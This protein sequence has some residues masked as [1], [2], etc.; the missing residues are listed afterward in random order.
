MASFSQDK[1]PAAVTIA[2][3][4]TDVFE[5]YCAGDWQVI[6]FDLTNAGSTA[7]D[8]IDIMAKDHKDGSFYILSATV[9]AYTT[10]DPETLAGGGVSR[11]TIACGDLYAVKLRA[12]VAAGSTTAT[13]TTLLTKFGLAGAKESGGNL[14]TIAALLT[15]IDIDTSKIPPLPSTQGKQDL[16][17]AGIGTN[18]DVPLAGETVEG[19]TARS[20]IS[21]WKRV[22][23]KLIDIK[24]LLVKG[25]ALKA[26]S[27]SV[28]VATDD[29][30]FGILGEAAAA[31]GAIHAQLR[32]I[33]EAVATQATPVEKEWKLL[34]L[35]NV[36]PGTALEFNGAVA[37][38][39]FCRAF[40]IQAKKV[41]GDNTGNIVV[42][43]SA[44]VRGSA[45]QIEVTPGAV[46]SPPLVAGVKIDI[47]KWFMDADNA[48][49]TIIIHY[50]EV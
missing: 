26:A 23:N 36:T 5:V 16:V 32:S 29:E 24:A 47:N 9:D 50:L 20:G 45:E 4:L 2:D 7:F 37:T 43:T 44:T 15:T 8:D 49:D 18:T 38:P 21:L 10:A 22:V 48:G 1:T 6:R 12:K 34:T 39:L 28:T 42:G 14:D 17:I 19:A 46:F 40:Y 30:Q 35:A 11:F 41:T 27:L 31:A 25:D 13:C 33:A 3:S